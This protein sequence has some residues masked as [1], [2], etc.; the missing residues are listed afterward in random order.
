MGAGEHMSVMSKCCDI[1]NCG[2]YLH[3]QMPLGGKEAARF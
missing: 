1:Q 3:V 2:Q